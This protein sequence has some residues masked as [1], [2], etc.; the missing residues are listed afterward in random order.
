MRSP[1]LVD[2]V[3]LGAIPALIAEAERI[4]ALLFARLVSP[5]P[6]PD[7]P[8]SDPLL[9][10]KQAA[11]FLNVPVSWV[12]ERG[13]TGA[14]PSVKLGHYMRFRRADLER[15]MATLEA[16][17]GPNYTSGTLCAVRKSGRF[18]GSSGGRKASSRKNS[19]SHRTP[20]PAG[21]ETSEASASPSLS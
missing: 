1:S 13:R 14:L 18:G 21:S 3:A 7:A 10:P 6:V 12:R 20:S 16:G 11:Q 19:A 2:A 5:R 9:T 8:A 15:A 4:K 17:P